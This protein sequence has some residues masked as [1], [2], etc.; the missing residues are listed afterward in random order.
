MNTVCRPDP[1]K[2]YCRGMRLR[3][4]SQRNARGWIRVL[5]VCLLVSAGPTRAS[6]EVVHVWVTSADGKQRLTSLPPIPFNAGAPGGSRIRV[7]DARRYQPVEGFG[8]S[9]TESSAWLIQRR[10]N[11]TQRRELM[12]ELFDPESGLGLSVTRVPIGA[13]DFSLEHHS[14]DDMPPGKSDPQLASFSIGRARADVLPL[15]REARRINPSLKVF[16]SPWSAPGW[17]KTSDSLIKGKLQPRH[18]GAFAAYFD[19][20]LTA[21]KAEGV[22]V[23]AMTM[24][25]EPHFEPPDYPG[26]RMEPAERAAFIASHLGPM[27]K[28]KWPQV[29]LLDWDHNWDEPQSPLAVLADPRARPYV[30]GIAWHC[31]GGDV[32]AQSQIHQKY[33]DTETWMTE[34]SGGNWAPQWSEVLSWMTR[35]LVIGNVRHWGRGANLWNLALDENHGPHLGGCGDC[36]GVVTID[37]KTG[38][39]TRNV[40]YYVLGHASRFVKPGAH[41][42]ESDTGIDGLETVAFRN[43]GAGSTVLIVLNTA[44]EPRAFSVVIDTRA[45]SATLDAGSVAT[46]TWAQPTRG[47]R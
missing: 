46:M 16:I 2:R 8:A 33:P 9:F 37:S 3:T 13:S 44:A 25:N 7:D 42:I 31:Y 22:P 41:R 38:A 29:R 34:C 30:H 45:F 36:R 6:G 18:Y 28:R 35:N 27:L 39:V 19:E 5:A 11:A 43:A 32:S 26:M 17:M 15:L 10:M 24:Q 47:K 20:T 12:R 23:C 1:P 14:Y 4:T 21:F 40:E